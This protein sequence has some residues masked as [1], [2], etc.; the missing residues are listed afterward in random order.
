MQAFHDRGGVD[1]VSLAHGASDVGVKLGQAD[2]R[3]KKYPLYVGQGNANSQR[4]FN[5]VS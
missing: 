5:T 3:I 1:E 4:V 2:L